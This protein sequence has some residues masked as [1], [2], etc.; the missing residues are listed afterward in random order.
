MDYVQKLFS[1][2]RGYNRDSAFHL[3]IAIT[4]EPEWS[5]K[6]RSKC[7]AE[8]MKKVRVAGWSD[9]IGLLSL[10]VDAGIIGSLY[11]S[12][13]V[14]LETAKR[15]T[16]LSQQNISYYDREEQLGVIEFLMSYTIP[17]I[18]KQYD[19]LMKIGKYNI[20]SSRTDALDKCM[21][22][23][24]TLLSKSSSVNETSS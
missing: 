18:R 6:Y 12:T 16:E 10:V 8:Y 9:L 2:R 15:I 1:M 14:R 20:L 13:N 3:G 5:A 4:K 24:V 11:S 23:L 22:A 17:E 21:Q 7:N 19:E